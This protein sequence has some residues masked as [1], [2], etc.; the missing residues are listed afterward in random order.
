MRLR[1]TISC[2]AAGGLVV[3]ASFAAELKPEVSNNPTRVDAPA[4]ENGVA[5]PDSVAKPAASA[6]GMDVKMMEEMM[7]AGA[8]GPQHEQLKKLTGTFSAK[9]TMKMAPDAPDM[10]SKGE[11]KSEMIL[12]GRIQSS[13]YAGDMMGQPFKGLCFVGFDNTKQKWFTIWM[14]DMSTMAMYTEG[15]GS[16]D[17]KTVTYTGEMPCP[18]NGGKMTP[19]RQV[20]TIKS[21]DS[22]TVEMFSKDDKGKEFRGMLLEYTRVR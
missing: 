12:G 18:A 11:L 16:A 17:H 8:P 15:T 9:C 4:K 5:T 2:L 1:T 7:K 10:S 13:T 20:V 14:D 21:D 6:G 3:C 19:F 22:Y